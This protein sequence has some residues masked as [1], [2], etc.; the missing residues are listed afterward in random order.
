MSVSVLIIKRNPLSA[1]RARPTSSS[2]LRRA[3]AKKK[4]LLH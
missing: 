3:F 1:L 4:N 2:L